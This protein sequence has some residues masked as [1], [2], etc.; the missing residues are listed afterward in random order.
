MAPRDL[1]SLQIA[2]LC[3]GLIQAP[4][5]A[6]CLKSIPIMVGNGQ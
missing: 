6:S 4:R 3:S 5:S 1:I 2:Q